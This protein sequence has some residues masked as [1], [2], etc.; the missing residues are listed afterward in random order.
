MPLHAGDIID[1]RYEVQRLL[2]QGGLG[3]VYQAVQ[4]STVQMVAIKVIQPSTHQNSDHE[5]LIRQRFT[6]EMRL[7]G[8]L[9]HPNIVRLIDA[10]SLED[11]QLF[12]VFE[13]VQGEELAAVLAREG[14][15]SVR[16]SV[17]L[18]GQVLEAL[19]A[20]H[21]Q[22]IVHRDLKPQNIMITSAGSRRSAVVLDFGIAA[23]VE[24]ARGQDY[25]SLTSDGYIPGTPWYMAPE[26]F[27]GRVTPQTDIYA[28]GLVLLECLTGQQAIPADT[29][30]Q[31]MIWQA[32]KEEVEIPASLLNH[33]IGRAVQRA[34]SKNLSVR[35]LT[36]AQGLRDLECCPLDEIGSQV[37]GSN[38]T[39][40]VHGNANLMDLT[41]YEGT[42]SP[43]ISLPDAAAETPLASSLAART[44][45]VTAP[46]LSL[47][48]LSSP[49]DDAFAPTQALAPVAPSPLLSP[50]PQPA[51][52]PKKP[53]ISTSSV[54]RHL[55][56]IAIIVIGLGLLAVA[57][58]LLL[59]PPA[60][61][62]NQSQS[63]NQTSGPPP[64]IQAP[65]PPD[66]ADTHEP[67]ATAPDTTT[68]PD[69]ATAPDTSQTPITTVPGAGALVWSIVND[70]LRPFLFLL[71]KSTSLAREDLDVLLEED[72]ELWPTFSEFL[73][74]FPLLV[75]NPSALPPFPFPDI[76]GFEDTK[77]TVYYSPFEAL[78]FAETICDN[79]TTAEQKDVCSVCQSLAN[80]YLS[81][82]A[83]DCSH[84]ND[85]LVGLQSQFEPT[86]DALRAAIRSPTDNMRWILSACD[87]ATSPLRV[88]FMASTSVCHDQVTSREW[89]QQLAQDGL[90]GAEDQHA[91]SLIGLGEEDGVLGFWDHEAN[92]FY[93]LATIVQ[94]ITEN[95]ET[96]E[97]INAFATAFIAN[98]DQFCAQSALFLQETS[99]CD[100]QLQKLN[101]FID[102]HKER[103]RALLNALKQISTLHAST[104][105]FA[106]TRYLT[107]H[108][109]AY[110]HCD[111]AHPA[112]L[113]LYDLL[114]GDLSPTTP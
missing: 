80:V 56:W 42:N 91:F 76:E 85:A 46:E 79:T 72:I 90:F 20:A 102:E 6:R 3:L 44:T 2:G 100:P 19:S 11:G 107:S 64:T 92:Q 22:G 17:R 10:G 108:Q 15:L 40:A 1:G 24:D 112:I 58:A 43:F 94:H 84:L 111:P 48:D 89:L 93:P 113:T 18:M 50:P 88:R 26:Q 104:V 45:P 106:C 110:P 99:D 86:H 82:P 16:E 63:Q 37:T 87:A 7:V 103:V 34:V 35:Y 5:A 55:P 53:S 59:R 114:A 39:A 67:T 4:R 32:S 66:A 38:P 98:L 25:K 33:P 101:T 52:P 29:P 28:W 70:P 96:E 75:G 78:S 27:D 62:Q 30:F 47:D 71:Q 97:Y 74:I 31:A 69:T 36:A 61:N 57:G 105:S 13:F 95:T 23:V 49:D 9:R 81:L 83:E 109:V 65:S 21:D 51:H 60:E 8:Q 12:T 77:L 54:Q 68:A 14:A 73:D 41:P